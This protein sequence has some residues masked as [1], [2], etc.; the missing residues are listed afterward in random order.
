MRRCMLVGSKTCLIGDRGQSCLNLPK[1][2]GPTTAPEPFSDYNYS[3]RLSVHVQTRWVFNPAYRLRAF[4]SGQEWLS[5][6]KT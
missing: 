4:A 6:A 5:K 1:W 2:A 3:A